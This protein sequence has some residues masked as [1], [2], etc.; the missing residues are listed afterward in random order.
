MEGEVRFTLL[1]EDGVEKEV[2]VFFFN[3]FFW[4][5]SFYFEWRFGQNW[6]IRD[7]YYEARLRKKNNIIADK[8]RRNFFKNIYIVLP[9]STHQEASIELSFVL[10]GSVGASEKNLHSEKKLVSPFFKTPP[11]DFVEE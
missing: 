1:D 5:T 8:K 6:P 3:F 4:K 10:F 11:E 9:R 2:K 7:Q